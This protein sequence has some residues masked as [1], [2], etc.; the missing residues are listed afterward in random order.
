M[1]GH[2]EEMNSGNGRI[3]L[4]TGSPGRTCGRSPAAICLGC[5]LA[6]VEARRRGLPQITE[7]RN[8]TGDSSACHI[9]NA[10]SLPMAQGSSSCAAVGA[11]SPTAA[12]RRWPCCEMS[13]VGMASCDMLLVR[14]CK[15]LSAWRWD[16]V[17]AP[18]LFVYVCSSGNSDRST[19]ISL[20]CAMLNL[21]DLRV[22][23]RI[24]RRR[25]ELRASWTRIQERAG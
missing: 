10:G 25:A 18:S 21:R 7:S 8:A 22:S 16:E 17:R 6:C 1:G 13:G 23:P 5:Q 11:P 19:S 20:C 14:L 3:S 9:S 12:S 2:A 4:Y 24:V 15:V